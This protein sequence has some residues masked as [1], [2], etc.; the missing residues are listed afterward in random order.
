[1]E[2]DIQ[3]NIYF[4]LGFLASQANQTKASLTKP[5]EL[6]ENIEK[7]NLETKEITEHGNTT[8]QYQLTLYKIEP[9]RK[10]ENENVNS[11]TQKNEDKQEATIEFQFSFDTIQSKKEITIRKNRS[12]F[13]YSLQ[14]PKFDFVELSDNEQITLFKSHL[15]K[16]K[17]LPKQRKALGEDSI[18]VVD[19]KQGKV[20]FDF[21]FSIFQ[22]VD[23]SELIQPLMLNFNIRDMIYPNLNYCQK[24]VALDRLL[25]NQKILFKGIDILNE[26]SESIKKAKK[27]KKDKIINKFYSFYLIFYQ[28]YAKDFLY[29]MLKTTKYKKSII[30]SLINDCNSFKGFDLTYFS[31]FFEEGSNLFID[32]IK[33]AGK[34]RLIIT[35]LLTL[36]Q[37]LNTCLQIINKYGKKINEFLSN[38]AEPILISQLVSLSRNDDI[39]ALISLYLDFNSKQNDFPII[40]FDSKIMKDYLE[41]YTRYNLNSIKNLHTIIE[42]IGDKDINEAYINSFHVTLFAFIQEGKLSNKEMVDNIGE[43]TLFFTNPSYED[44][45]SFANNLSLEEDQITDNII[46]KITSFKLKELAKKVHQNNLNFFLMILLN[47]V[48]DFDKF[49]IVYKILCKD[50]ETDGL[51]ELQKHFLNVL[52]NSEKIEITMLAN[53]ILFFMTNNTINDFLTCL[54]RANFQYIFDS[55]IQILTDYQE[56]ISETNSNHIVKFLISNLDKSKSNKSIFSLIKQL[57]KK[58]YSL[59]ALVQQIT[60]YSIKYSDLLSPKISGNLQL[61]IDLHKEHYFSQYKNIFYNTQYYNTSVVHLKTFY[62]DL[63]K[64]K[65]NYQSIVSLY[66]MKTDLDERL[67]LLQMIGIKENDI[68]HYKEE[69]SKQYNELSSLKDS[70]DILKTYYSFYYS[71]SK[72]KSKQID[73][74]LT[75][76]LNVDYS[77]FSKQTKEE[78]KRVITSELNDTIKKQ[79]L[80]A[81]SFY[82]SLIYNNNRTTLNSKNQEEIKT[83]SLEQ[84]EELKKLLSINTIDQIDENIMKIILEQDIDRRGIKSEFKR[85]KAY[86]NIQKNTEKEEEKMINKANLKI[87]YRIAKSIITFIDLIDVSKTDYYVKLKKIV[88][89]NN[90][91][92]ISQILLKEYGINID[93]MQSHFLVIQS[94]MKNKDV[95]PFIKDKKEE[96]VR[97][98][99]E[100]IQDLFDQIITLSDIKD[101]IKIINLF[102][103]LKVKKCKTDKELIEGLKQLCLNQKYKNIE[104]CLENIVNNFSP[105]KELYNQTMNKSEFSKEKLKQLYTKSEFTLE[106]IGGKTTIEVHYQSFRDHTNVNISFDSVLELRERSLLNKQIGE[107][108]DNFSDNNEKFAEIVSKISDLKISLEQLADKGY[109]KGCKIII[110]INN[111]IP[112]ITFNDDKKYDINTIVNDFDE[113]VA[114]LTNIQSEHYSKDNKFTLFYG[115]LFTFFIEAIRFNRVNHKKSLQHFIRY[116]TNN[117]GSANIDFIY[118]CND[119]TKKNDTI[120]NDLMDNCRNYINQLFTRYNIKESQF[121]GYKQTNEKKISGIYTILISD[122]IWEKSVVNTYLHFTGKLP[123]SYSVLLCNQQTSTEEIIAFLYRA[124]TNKENLLFSII[125]PECL[126]TEVEH[127]MIEKIMSISQTNAKMESALLFFYSEEKSPIIQQIKQLRIG[128]I[129]D[130]S[131]INEEQIKVDTIIEETTIEVISSDACGIGKTESIK[132][133]AKDKKLDYQYFPLGGE[134]SRIDVLNRL[135]DIDIKDNK[136]LIHLDLMQTKNKDILR[137]FLFSFLV[138]KKYALREYIFYLGNKIQIKIEIPNDFINFTEKFKVL[139]LFK[140][141]TLLSSKLPPLQISNDITSNAQIIANYIYLVE[142]KLINKNDLLIPGLKTKEDVESDPEYDKKTLIPGK[143]FSQ[144]EC[145]KYIYDSLNKTS[146]NFYQI[147]AFINVLGEQFKSFIKSIYLNVSA[148]TIKGKEKREK[149]LVEIRE[150]LIKCLIKITSFFTKGSFDDLLSN[151]NLYESQTFRFDEEQA[152]A[153]ATRKLSYQKEEFISFKKID[154]SLVFFNNDGESLS[155]ISNLDRNSNEYQKLKTLYNS[156]SNENKNELVDYYHLKDLQY[157]NQIERILD[158]KPKKIIKNGQI[159]SISAYEFLLKT[160]GN[161]AFTADN[162]SKMILI[163]LRIRAKIPVIM[164]GETGCGKTSLIRKLSEFLENEMLIFNIHA[165]ITD[166]DII[167]FCEKNNL[168]NGNDNVNR[169]GKKKADKWVFLDE[170]NTCNSMGLIKE[171]M[172][173]RTMQGKKINDNVVFIAACNPYKTIGDNNQK[174]I[175]LIKKGSKQSNLVYLVNPLPSSLLTFVFNFGNLTPEDEAIYIERIIEEPITKTISERERSS[176]IKT[177]ASNAIN[178]CQKFIRESNDRSSVSLRE[179]RRFVIFYNWF[180]EH[181]KEFENKKIISDKYQNAINS[182]KLSIYLCY[183]L[184]IPDKTLRQKLSGQLDKIFGNSFSEFPHK[185]EEK[186]CNEIN[187]E[188]GIAKNRALLENIFTLFVCINTK[189]PVI[190]CGKPGC[191]KSLSF[192]LLYKSMKGQDS[193]QDFFKHFPKL[194]INSYQG[195]ETSTSEGVLKIFKKARGLLRNEKEKDKMISLIYFDEMGLAEISPNNPLKVIHSE[196][197]YDDNKDKIAFV[198]ISNWVLDAAKMNRAVYLSIPEP[199]E[200]DLIT[201]GKSIAESYRL[202][203]YT[204]FQSVFDGLSKTYMN[205]KTYLQKNQINFYDFHGSRDFYNM[206]KKAAKKLIGVTSSDAH[207]K[208]AAANESI[209]RNFGGLDFSIKT[210]KEFYIKNNSSTNNFPVN[211]YKIKDCLQSNLQEIGSRFLLLISKTSLSPYLISS[212]IQKIGKKSNF[213]IGSQFENDQMSELYTAKLLNK[214]QL[215]MEQDNV[216]ILKNLTSIYPSL[217]DLFNQNYTVMG[218]K[219]FAR[220]A[221]GYSNNV[222]AQVN[223]NFRCVVLIDE[224]EIQK[225]DPPFLNRFEKHIVTF[226][227]LILDDFKKRVNEVNHLLHDFIIPKDP[228]RVINLD[229]SKMLINCDHDEINALVYDYQV[230]HS[231]ELETNKIPPEIFGKIALTFSQDIIA[232]GQYSELKKSNS[233][234][235]KMILDSY[236]KGEHT[237]IKNYLK[238]MTSTNNV[239]YTYSTV[240]AQINIKDE[241]D[242]SVFGKIRNNTIKTIIIATIKEERELEKHI[243]NF[244]MDAQQNVCILKFTNEDCI[245]LSHIMYFI[246]NMKNSIERKKEKAIV[247]IIYLQRVYKDKTKKE[248][249][250][251]VENNFLSHLTH[252]NQI[253]IDNLNGGEIQFID[254]IGKNN[255]ELLIDSKLIQVDEEITKRIEQSINKLEFIIKDSTEENT[256]NKYKQ[257][258][259]QL[260]RSNEAAVREQ[261]KKSLINY[262]KTEPPFLFSIFDKYESRISDEEPDLISTL[263]N[264]MKGK[265]IGLIDSFIF[266]AE[267]KGILYTYL[268]QIT[269]K[270]CEQFND[271]VFEESTKQLDLK[272][273]LFTEENT[274]HVLQGLNIPGSKEDFL[275]VIKYAK[276]LA[277]NYVNIENEYKF[278]DKDKEMTIE[279]EYNTKI[280][281]YENNTEIEIK[282]QKVLSKLIELGITSKK[283]KRMILLD[284]CL[285]YLSQQYNTKKEH[286]QELLLF[287]IERKVN[288]LNEIDFFKNLSKQIIWVVSYSKIINSILSIFDTLDKYI[289]NLLEKVENT[290]TEKKNELIKNERFSDNII[291]VNQVFFELFEGII[292]QIIRNPQIF[293]TESLQLYQ[294]IEELGNIVSNGLQIELNL[295]L[296]SKEIYILQ[297]FLKVYEIIQRQNN[298]NQTKVT[299]LTRYIEIIKKGKEL[300]KEDNIE[301]KINNLKEEYNF[302]NN[303]LNKSKELPS[304]ISFVLQNKYKMENNLEIYTNFLDIILKNNELLMSSKNL[305]FMI[306]NSSHYQHLTPT[307]DNQNDF[308]HFASQDDIFLS[309]LEKENNNILDE[310]LLFYFESIFFEYFTEIKDKLKLDKIELTVFKDLSQPNGTQTSLENLKLALAYIKQI[311]PNNPLKHIGFLYSIAYI[312]YYLYL[313]VKGLTHQLQKTENVERI[314]DAIDDEL[315]NSDIR[316]SIRIYILKLFRKECNSYDEFKNYDWTLHKITWIQ[317]FSFEEKVKSF[318]DFLFLKIDVFAQYQEEEKM[319][320]EYFQNNF[321]KDNA[322]F[323]S[324]IKNHSP[325]IFFDLSIN[326]IISNLI[327]ENYSISDEYNNYASLALSIIRNINLKENQKKVLELIFNSNT[328]NTKIIPKIK[329]KKLSE[330]EVILY[331]LKFMFFSSLSNSQSFYYQITTERIKDILPNSYIPGGEPRDDLII[332][333]YY[334]IENFL[335]ETQRT[336]PGAYVC[337]CGYFYQIE[338]CSM[339]R[340][341]SKCPVCGED[342][343]GENHCLIKREGHFRVYLNKEQKTEIESKSWYGD[344]PSKLLADFKIQIDNMLKNEPQGIKTVKPLFFK[345][346]KVVRGL[347]YLS[348]RI[349]SFILYSNLYFSNILGFIDDKKLEDYCHSLKCEELLWFNWTEI[350]KELSHHKINNIHIYMNMIFNE[351]PNILGTFS[352]KT[353]EERKT[354]ETSFTKFITSSLSR[355]NE[356][357]QNYI[358][359]NAELLKTTTKSLRGLIQETVPPDEILSYPY[360]KYLIVPKYPD[361]QSIVDILNSEGNNKY[362]ITSNYLNND[363]IILLE[364]LKYLNPLAKLLINKYSYKISR[365]EAKQKSIIEE[366]NL[367]GNN[368]N[369]EQLTE[370]IESYNQMIG[371]G[372]PI[373]C[374]AISDVNLTLD[375][376][377]QLAYFLNDDGE[378]HYGINLANIYNKLISIQN[379]FLELAV[380]KLDTK[381]NLG[382]FKEQVNKD[383][384]IQDATYAEI[385]NF[386]LDNACFSSFESIIYMYSWRDCF[387]DDYTINYN[388][389]SNITYNLQGIENELARTLLPGKRKFKVEQKYVVY[390]NESF[391]GDRSS[392]LYNFITK[393][394]QKNITYD[395]GK[396]IQQ[397]IRS[398]D[399]HYELLEALNLLLNYLVKENAI[400]TISIKDLINQDTF[401]LTFNED[402][403]QFFENND[404]I[405]V[406]TLQDVYEYIEYKSYNKITRNMSP[407]YKV[408]IDEDT[409]NKIEKFYSNPR[410]LITKEILAKAVRKYISRNFSSRRVFN[411]FNPTSNLL[412]FIPNG[413]DRTDYWDIKICGNKGFEEIM[414]QVKLY[415]N[416]KIKNAVD[417]YN[418]LGGDSFE[419][420]N[421]EIEPSKENNTNQLN[422]ENNKEERINEVPKRPVVRKKVKKYN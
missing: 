119:T 201:T 128:K 55:Y 23:D 17:I 263:R 413:E 288:S 191:S 205:Y 386:S 95:Y 79:T 381:E 106:L 76:L 278:I 204:T 83:K 305:I 235:Y 368:F 147:N 353:S 61:L 118:C 102:S 272:E 185:I 117:S 249:N 327:K 398:E 153:N 1:M 57:S 131:Y 41:L 159:V 141:K 289:P 154:K 371:Q 56:S 390:K 241:I 74:Q 276:T 394:P 351:F 308:L 98:L 236:K 404:T 254:I 173:N 387:N 419:F 162:F 6:F 91:E 339:P 350:Q 361:C 209:E 388:N 375:E 25:K 10:V 2:K 293:M 175:G 319:F 222:F 137:E 142:N 144:K 220:I 60:K 136:T 219:K 231:D 364:H 134:F 72:D 402:F 116:L 192:Q 87:L 376:K 170:I 62:T 130:S 149:K 260:V 283:T 156:N 197:E 176:E 155:I 145:Q 114:L 27:E 218:K 99:T 258:L 242:N 46:D 85:I 42:R 16:N 226:D 133:Y 22:L 290:I 247:M 411:G 407:L 31:L 343:G 338:N 129:L 342:I 39:D 103:E 96:D 26:D 355:Y 307:I 374:D 138:L 181:I 225:Q 417:F 304:L 224:T 408:S 7:I 415:C 179:I 160:K 190:I 180:F 121:F 110:K 418:I 275:S 148:L 184:R 47:K 94:I 326:K 401:P 250:G 92:Q 194:Y 336:S 356:Y 20:T 123:L 52:S 383:I 157:L 349:L 382:F 178:K 282:N 59:K 146:K 345:Q 163:I 268:K 359:K 35:S 310:I 73:E 111:A 274:I 340:V 256:K 396:K 13:L 120:F 229:I 334:A 228:T 379:G 405:K 140:M 14:I 36:S 109:P 75:K 265:L 12:N 317:D 208:D 126:S 367:I 253:F 107:D 322:K 303:E 262:F 273:N 49:Q 318:L 240:F 50:L 53:I 357:Q 399:K 113:T 324:L 370:F 84:A 347:T 9:K 410:E 277:D 32:I 151:Q 182:V 312:K 198:G 335:K 58:Q 346:K 165:G 168:V 38:E 362:P 97:N 321:R 395:E 292:Y 354:F 78:I 127:I 164:M 313:Y 270:D 261:I 207:L 329:G 363:E 196:L 299:Q 171:M 286:L 373:N 378:L 246:E 403:K 238:T 43:D 124:I 217:Y 189:V 195:S 344:I 391:T 93:S 33:E 244:F 166:K 400:E 21:F 223:D 51:N 392:L 28:Y 369:R 389:Y 66:N 48:S 3:N 316:N 18:K 206:I 24:R 406:N 255:N 315:G 122:E 232:F 291:R 77:T 264:Y 115:R 40:Q 63:S 34:N 314:S 352:F 300:M 239:I 139:K 409:I 68:R 248:D 366:L 279:N 104:A 309:K 186:I 267:K 331:A 323:V 82:F 167:D 285:C 295:F 67:S 172:C 271:I 15:I 112:T 328:L 245:H 333:S 332:S 108:D 297:T 177:I 45:Q 152:Q 360:M 325:I 301:G 202:E 213:F 385:V 89:D 251:L 135:L 193:E 421:A 372:E 397:L 269:N 298:D 88:E 188:E 29:E 377:K 212:I 199:D 71:F 422:N 70:L 8:K 80:I 393:Y 211:D 125:R 65:L 4:I 259:I 169:K 420:T 296:F 19:K 380:R 90:N 243:Y 5:N 281:Q 266:A 187:I 150:F 252:Y 69:L 306:L 214:I 233:G 11:I 320:A 384:Y 183:Y 100:F 330:F 311:Q 348:Y 230:N 412:D 221:L 54:E 161:Y 143:V 294:Y 158:I 234:A 237:N 341:K 86:F 105:I 37:N 257:R 203:I 132:Q 215:C 302:L 280:S 174:K 64:N 101:L 284:F 210:A 81:K 44:I 200:E 414:D 365:E 30:N 337:S 287:I 216:L 416:V 227:F 358:N